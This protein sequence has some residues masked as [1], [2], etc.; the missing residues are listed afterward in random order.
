MR[1]KSIEKHLKDEVEKLGGKAFKFT[2]PGNAGVPDRIVIIKGLIKFVE[3]KRPGK[4]LRPVQKFRKKQFEQLGVEVMVL[5]SK[6]K[7]DEFIE[8]C[9]AQLSGRS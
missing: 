5:D 9:T 8:I 4:D 2:S 7:V 1:E 6:E 3:L